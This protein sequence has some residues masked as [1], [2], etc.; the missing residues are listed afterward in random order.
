MTRKLRAAV[1]AGL[2]AALLL[3]VGCAVGDPQLADTYGWKEEKILG[4]QPGET[5]PNQNTKPGAFSG[6]LWRAPNARGT[7]VWIHGGSFFNGNPNEIN[8]GGW[9]PIARQAARGYN[10]LSIYYQTPNKFPGAVLDGAAAV[11]WAQ[12][13]LSSRVF[14]AGHSAGGTVAALIG[15]HAG[16]NYEGR[17]MPRVSGWMSVAGILVYNEADGNFETG[18]RILRGWLAGQVAPGGIGGTMQPSDQFR[19]A[20]LVAYNLGDPPGYVIQSA[21]DPQITGLNL[22]RFAGLVGQDMTMS[23]DLVDYYATGEPISRSLG[24]NG[25]MHWPIKGASVSN[26]DHFL[27]NH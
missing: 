2:A 23:W 25:D 8:G 9:G 10:I 21:S 27:D 14:V 5:V 24:F 13:N 19:V 7:I 22:Y 20:P 3:A 18:N 6:L 15:L 12:Q 26:I 16:D 1:T 17:T 11:E 4:G